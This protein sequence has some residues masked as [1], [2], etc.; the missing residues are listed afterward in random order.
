MGTLLVLGTV[1]AAA[2]LT[3][4]VAALVVWLRRPPR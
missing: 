1:I 2:A 3:I 4:G